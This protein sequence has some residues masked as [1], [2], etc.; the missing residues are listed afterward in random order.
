MGK[1]HEDLHTLHEAL[2]RFEHTVVQREHRKPFT[3]KVTT[4]QEAD[5]ARQHV[6][7]VVVQM[8]TNARLGRESSGKPSAG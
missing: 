7:E 4:Q 8:V 2:A 6:V 5:N 3:S 1:G